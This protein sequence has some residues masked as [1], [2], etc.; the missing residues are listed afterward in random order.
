MLRHEFEVRLGR[1]KLHQLSGHMQEQE[2]GASVSSAAALLARKICENTTIAS[3]EKRKAQ[4]GNINM[5]PKPTQ[6]R[7]N[8]RDYPDARP[9]TAPFLPR[10]KSKSVLGGSLPHTDSI[11]S[12][13]RTSSK[14]VYSTS[15]STKL[16]KT[17]VDPS[18]ACVLLYQV[19]NTEAPH[20]QTS[21]ATYSEIQR[22]RNDL[23]A[24]Q[25]KNNA[26]TQRNSR[27]QSQNNQWTEK[28]RIEALNRT[29]IFKLSDENTALKASQRESNTAMELLNQT[30]HVVHTQ[31][32]Q[33]ESDVLEWR[34]NFAGLAEKYAEAESDLQT[35]S[36]EAYYWKVQFD[37]LCF[38]YV[39][40]KQ[41]FDKLAQVVHKASDFAVMD[42]P[43]MQMKKG[44]FE[45]S[46][47][48]PRP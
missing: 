22:L 4:Y 37:M 25:Q 30:L 7:H 32:T 39:S 6:W 11:S 28:F 10:Y 8:L 15:T 33:Q 34:H 14:A 35:N 29:Y 18:D 13:T 24:C 16:A 1:T 23:E 31:A 27:L 47:S 21:T 3:F 46:L 42:D 2:K 12:P 9:S 36:R 17:V 45:L 43:I 44:Y 38:K 48:F 40:L 41:E 20:A 19:A 26:L 5:R